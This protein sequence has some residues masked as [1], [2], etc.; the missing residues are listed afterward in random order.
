VSWRK[1]DFDDLE[2][3]H[4]FYFILY[5]IIIEESSCISTMYRLLLEIYVVLIVKKEVI[6]PLL[7]QIVHQVYFHT[8]TCKA[9]LGGTNFS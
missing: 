4:V 3:L 8:S 2:D 9:C 1:E 7:K 6:A 5:F